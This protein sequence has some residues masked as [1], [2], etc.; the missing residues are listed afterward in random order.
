MV[1]IEPFTNHLPVRISFGS[2]RFAE[3]DGIL[4][5][6]GAQRPIAFVDPALRD[7]GSVVSRLPP[8]VDISFV[9]PGEPTTS[10]IDAAGAHVTDTRP[11]AIVAIGGGSTLDT[12]K[13]ARLVSQSHRSIRAYGWPVEDRPVPPL[14]TPLITVPTTAGTGSEVT[15]GAVFID[16]EIGIKLAAVGPHNRAYACIVD[17]ELTYTLPRGP[18]LS[19]GLDVLAQAIGPIIAKTHT[20]VGDGLAFEALRLVPRALTAVVF[21][22]SDAGARSE[23][24]C[25]S[26]L[27]GLAMNVS[28]AGTDHSLG[29]ALGAV[30]KIPHGLSVGLMLPEAMEH[31]RRYV[32]ERFERIADALGV[33][34]TKDADGSRAVEAVRHFLTSVNCPTL[35]E[36]GGDEAHLDALVDASFVRA[37]DTGRAITV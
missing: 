26:L 28:E 15:G 34:P 20:P 27:A 7:A 33:P 31:E 19:G 10:S 32:P 21:D 14:R 13:G 23:M 8:S 2:G 22:G 25:A 6:L 29:H 3:L 18:T 9:R 12:A 17:P 11:D 35:R 4:D 36:L 16:E 37:L 24:A 1:G 30:L 5:Q